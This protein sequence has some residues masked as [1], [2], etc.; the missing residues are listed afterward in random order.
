VARY[1]AG[2]VSVYAIDPTTGALAPAGNPVV[3]GTAPRS[4]VADSTGR[5]QHAQ[6]HLLKRKP[7][8]SR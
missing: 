1:D 8:S 7:P 3:T 4:V 2:E 6:L 5:D